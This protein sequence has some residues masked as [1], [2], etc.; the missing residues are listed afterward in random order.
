[1]KPWKTEQ[2]DATGS[3]VLEHSSQSSSSTPVITPSKSREK[4]IKP[5]LKTETQTQTNERRGICAESNPGLF[6]SPMMNRN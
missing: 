2:E 5:K 3:H 6:Q 1:M 4:T